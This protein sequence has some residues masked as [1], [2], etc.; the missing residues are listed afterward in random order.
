[1]VGVIG[2]EDSISDS[3]ARDEDGAID[4]EANEEAALK[5]RSGLL[6]VNFS[7]KSACD[8]VV[9]RRR[10]L[11]KTKYPV[12]PTAIPKMRLPTVEPIKIFSKSPLLL[13][14]QG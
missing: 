7:P 9:C 10:S 2:M 14:S 1:M 5:D 13:K 4:G 8:G 12:I 6:Q 11:R 3:G